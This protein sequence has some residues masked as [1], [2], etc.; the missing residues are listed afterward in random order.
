M[1]NPHRYRLGRPRAGLSVIEVL[2]ALVLVSV[3]LLGLAGTSALTLRSAGFAA[4]EHQAIRVAAVRMSR[5]TAAGC[6]ST[7]QSGAAADD[8]TRVTEQWTVDAPRNGGA[9][10]HVQV[11][12]KEGAG[13]RTLT[14][15]GGL[16]C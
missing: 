7:Q 6:P 1:R 15:E 8:A 12:W 5:L 9:T 3:G 4:R 10:V 14:L 13:M 2:F 16:L 11:A